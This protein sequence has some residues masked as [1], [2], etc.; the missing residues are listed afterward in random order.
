MAERN[1]I[2]IFTEAILGQEPTTLVR[3]AGA[4]LPT[5][6]EIQTLGDT[7]NVTSDWTTV[8]E[9]NGRTFID[10]NTGNTIFL[11]AVDWRS[12]VNGM[13][14]NAIAGGGYWS[15]AF[16]GTDGAWSLTFNS[17]FVGAGNIGYFRAWG[18]SVRCVTE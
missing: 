7:D 1:G 15:S 3:E 10:I 8:N 6:E 18:F 14:G 2:A 17:G 5:R 16:A 13:L 11:P 4:Y 9:V 12:Y